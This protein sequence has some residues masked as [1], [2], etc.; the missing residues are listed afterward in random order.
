MRRRDLQDRGRL[1]LV[2]AL[3]RL[4]SCLGAVRRDSFGAQIARVYEL[5]AS[6]QLEGELA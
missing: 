5:E 4:F 6:A 1:N 3:E 2:N